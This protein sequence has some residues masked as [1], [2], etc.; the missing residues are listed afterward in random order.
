MQKY[1]TFDAYPSFSYQIITHLIDSPDAEIIWKLLKYD[2][3]DAFAKPNLTRDE[4]KAMIYDGGSIATDFR[5]F[6]DQ[7]NADSVTEIMTLMRIY[8]LAL[9]PENYTNGVASINFEVYSH[10]ETNTMKNRR[11]KIDTI[12]QALIKSLNG[13]DIKGLGVL[14]FNANRSRY[15]K[16]IAVGLTPF[17]GK[18]L[19]MSTN[20][21]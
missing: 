4:K 12:V 3:N 1:A 10:S 11:T 18:C 14:F 6:I 17:K 2:T 21:S 13:K 7:G 5:V 15:D 8:P 16:T 19:T 9:I 20:I